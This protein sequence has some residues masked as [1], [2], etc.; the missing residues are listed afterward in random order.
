MEYGVKFD[1]S[2]LS[3]YITNIFF[4]ITSCEK[5]VIFVTEFVPLGKNPP[6]YEGFFFSKVFFRPL[7]TKMVKFLPYSILAGWMKYEYEGYTCVIVYR[8]YSVTL[9]LC[10]CSREHKSQSHQTN[11]RES[12][13]GF[14]HISFFHRGGKGLNWSADQVKDTAKFTWLVHGRAVVRFSNLGGLIF[15]DCL[16]ICLSGFSILLF[17]TPNFR[18]GGSDATPDPR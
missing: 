7:F 14:F 16:G 1:I 12:H 18:G 8:F 15:K 11:Q 2:S 6:F 3:T 9:H 5:K 4:E 10:R 17:W 13:V